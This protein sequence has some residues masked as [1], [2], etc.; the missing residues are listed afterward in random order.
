MRIQITLHKFA[1]VLAG[2]LL[3]PLAAQAQ[4]PAKA[5]P[6]KDPEFCLGCH[7]DLTEE[8]VV[9]MAVK[10]GCL[11]CHS[12]LDASVRPHK[13]NGKFPHGLDAAQPA[14]CLT[15]HSKLV[16]NK[17]MTHAAVGMGCTGCHEPHSSKNAKLLKAAAPA[18]CF[19]CHDKED[20]EGKFVHGPVKSGQCLTCHQ[21]HASDNQGLLK[22]D[23]AQMCLDCH[24][25]V[26]E[27]PHMIAGFSRKGHP[28]GDEKR[29]KPV[30][31]PMREGKLFYCASCHEPHRSNFEKL[32]RIDPKLG[33]LACQK[34]HE[35]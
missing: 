27:A 7:D 4:A 9:H 35:K 19:K 26:K 28:I 14:L 31:D 5:A 10:N 1:W 6:I 32:R 12:N 17:K 23:R 16:A 11:D 2:A 15:C 13:N 25:E 18:L 24:D 3:L 20:F 30:A 21:P 34:C 33:M 22:K 29:A 8:K